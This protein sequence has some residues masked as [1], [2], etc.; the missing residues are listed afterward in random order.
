MLLF[1][2]LVEL[3]CL[4]SDEYVQAVRRLQQGEALNNIDRFLL[5][6]CWD[7]VAFLTNSKR[8]SSL[9]TVC[10]GK[11]QQMCDE[12]LTR[13]EWALDQPV[14]MAPPS[15]AYI[16][17]RCQQLLT[18]HNFSAF[19]KHANRLIDRLVNI[20]VQPSSTSDGPACSHVAL[21]ALHNLAV[22]SDVRTLIQ[23]RQLAA[24][25]SK[26]TSS[27]SLEQ[28]TLAFATLA[29]IID[30]R[31]AN[32]RSVEMVTVFIEQLEQGNPAVTN[33]FLDIVLSSVKALMQHEVMKKELIKQGGVDLLVRLIRT[34]D[35]QQPSDQPLQDALEILWSC[36]FGNPSVVA[37]LKQDSMFMAR[38]HHLSDQTKGGKN[39][40]LSKAVEGLIWKVET[41]EKFKERQL[42]LVID[43]NDEKK[44]YDLTISYS[45]ADRDLVHRLFHHLTDELGYKVW[46][47]F[48]QVDG[49]TMGT[50]V[51]RRRMEHSQT[52]T[53]TF[54]LFCM[55][56]RMPSTM[57][58]AFSCA[59]P[60]RTNEA[61]AA[62]P[63]Q[64]TRS[65]ARSMSWRAQ[66]RVTTHPTDGSRA[67]SGRRNVS[68]SAH[69]RSRRVSNCSTVKFDC[70]R[71]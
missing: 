61:Y 25:V 67:F 4:N 66:C 34:T 14:P 49:S 26:Y 11:M 15:V 50:M 3:D 7:Y 13:L 42:S 1:C 60:T 31:E 12:I 30:E 5:F 39:H 10:D 29:Q 52:R 22:N 71:N 70:N 38:I 32:S 8:D 16:F 64:S 27:D 17:H 57:L 47:D 54:L 41:E 69:S 23:G 62:C 36:T 45:W 21:E 18:I 6:N 9:L 19:E 44:Q 53:L 37:T 28:R 56:R 2:C 33:P 65:F 43:D 63:K 48:E 46:L 55:N 24:L 59:S 51:G 58:T 68:I 20:L 40:A 35:L